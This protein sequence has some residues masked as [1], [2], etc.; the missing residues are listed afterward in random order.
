MYYLLFPNNNIMCTNKKL[1]CD[2]E[3]NNKC[4]CVCNEQKTQVM[5]KLI[6][7]AT[8]R[9]VSFLSE[10]GMVAHSFGY[11]STQLNVDFL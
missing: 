8:W 10:V 1:M 9:N 5:N 11:F 7:G 2:M 6:A 3:Y 4:V